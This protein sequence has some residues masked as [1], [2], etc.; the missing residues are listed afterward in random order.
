MDE[1]DT[2]RRIAGIVANMRGLA[3]SLD[4]ESRGRLLGLANEM[5][6]LGAGLSDSKV[7][8]AIK[9]VVSMVAGGLVGYGVGQFLDKLNYLGSPLG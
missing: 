6:R 1:A 4:A 3:N 2:K 8:A 9:S 5:D 7:K